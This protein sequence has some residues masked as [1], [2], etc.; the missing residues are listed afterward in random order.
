MNSLTRSQNVMRSQ[1]VMPSVGC[2]LLLSVMSALATPDTSDAKPLTASTTVIVSTTSPS[3]S[4]ICSC[5][6]ERTS[7]ADLT[8]SGERQGNPAVVVACIADL[9]HHVS[10]ADRQLK[11]DFAFLASVAVH[12]FIE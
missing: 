9:Q 2:S 12:H 4:W 8:A 11:D 7:G 3:S 10:R 6:Y 5:W 1:R